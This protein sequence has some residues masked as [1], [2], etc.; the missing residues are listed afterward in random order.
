M[1]S[2]HGDYAKSKNND[3]ANSE[4]GGAG[5]TLRL[6][7]NE[8]RG[9]WKGDEKHNNDDSKH[10]NTES[11]TEDSSASMSE[12][13]EYHNL[14]SRL[15]YLN[16]A[17]DEKSGVVAEAVRRLVEDGSVAG[18]VFNMCS[19]TLGA[20]VLAL[21][22]A[23]S[24]A[25]LLMALSL[26]MLAAAATLLSVDMLVASC[27]A[28]GLDSYE[29]LTATLFG[30]GAARVV[31]FCVLFFCVGVSVAYVVAVGD[32]L[33]QGV[34]GTIPALPDFFDRRVAMVLF[35]STVMFPLS[36][37]RR[38]NDVQVASMVG[39]SS[40]FFLVGVVVLH[41]VRTLAHFGT[42]PDTEHHTRD[43]GGNL[44]LFPDNAED[45][46]ASCPI[47][48][49]AFC[50]Q[51]NVPQIFH[52]LSASVSDSDRTTKLH[53][54]RRVTRG[55]VAVCVSAYMLIGCFAYLEFGDKTQGTI[56]LNFCVHRTKE[57]LTIVACLGVAVSVVLAFPLNV[58]PAR[59]TLNLVLDRILYG[60]RTPRGVF[61]EED[62]D[63][64][65]S[66]LGTNHHSL[67]DRF[68]PLQE[69]LLVVYRNSQHHSRHAHAASTLTP[70]GGGDDDDHPCSRARHF[71]T[72]LLVSGAAL[73]IALVVP[74]ISVV[75]GLMGGFCSSLI[76]F[77]L[78]A[79][80]FLR[81]GLHRRSRVAAAAARASMVL[82]TIVG[83]A[84]TVVTVRGLFVAPPGRED[85]CSVAS[86][87]TTPSGA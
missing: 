73:G 8:A 48:I 13:L 55:A 14:R 18:S 53:E 85:V 20:G 19:A 22:Y 26:L 81:L 29:T 3:D 24:K 79:G 10:N 63:D 2:E 64:L 43:R 70:G 36:L 27:A 47:I 76:G 44:K 71:V 42:S 67:E 23:F 32:I 61:D 54:M 6:A 25:G 52:E 46:L 7:G 39:I 86:N 56:L 34:L 72:T 84:T 65:S 37:R 51:V 41:S 40:I 45:V 31:E 28:T 35:W 69:P 62:V 21:P 30:R 33:E 15:R 87:G 75:F 12:Y 57:P 11:E 80:F 49:F 66:A 50:C 77:V 60:E 82:G 4:Q 59:N 68:S 38:V 16:P 17:N 1:V 78:P 9:S 74:D 83:I 58:F 5:R